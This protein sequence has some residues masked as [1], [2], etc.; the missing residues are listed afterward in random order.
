MAAVGKLLNYHE[1]LYHDLLDPAE[2]LPAFHAGTLKMSVYDALPALVQQLEA[3]KVPSP[4]LSELRHAMDTLFA[5]GKP[6]LLTYHHR[7]YL[8]HLIGMLKQLAG[9]RRQ[10]DW[11]K[12]FVESLVNYNFNYMGFFNRWQEARDGELEAARKDGS[13][14]A[15]VSG[16]YDTLQH[17]TPIPDLAF[18]PRQPSL[19]EHMT[20]YVCAKASAVVEWKNR[21]AQESP[22]SDQQ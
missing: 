11:S 4:Y 21:E 12:R 5:E 14:P 16:W 3:K 8:P 20:L 18:V 22:L 15:L 10:K 9:D 2:P 6:P 1:R 7:T 13:T 17:H 19:L